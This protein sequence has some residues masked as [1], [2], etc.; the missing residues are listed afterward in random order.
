MGT[1]PHREDIKAELRKKHGSVAEFERRTGLPKRSVKDV[2]D[3]KSRPEVAKAVAV[4][5]NRAPH[6]VFPD[7]FSPNGDALSRRNPA[8]QPLNGGGK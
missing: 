1:A 2:L 8:S 3:G 4:A 7:R 6:L 5:L